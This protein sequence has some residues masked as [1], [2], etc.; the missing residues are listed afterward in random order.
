MKRWLWQELKQALFNFKIAVNHLTAAETHKSHFAV[1]LVA[2][3]T[4]L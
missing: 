1:E 4:V 2:T 3:Y